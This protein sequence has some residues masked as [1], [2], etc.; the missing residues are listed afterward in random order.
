MITRNI[1][2]NGISTCNIN[3]VKY[4]NLLNTV[5]FSKFLTLYVNNDFDKPSLF[6]VNLLCSQFAAV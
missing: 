3:N 6:T 5:K 1:N 4:L 2:F